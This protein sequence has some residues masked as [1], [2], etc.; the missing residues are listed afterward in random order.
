MDTVLASSTRLALD[1]RGAGAAVVFLH[2]LTFSR[3]TWD[4]IL[5]RLAGRFR[6]VA[7]DLPGHGESPRLPSSIEEV[8]YRIHALII[9]LGIDRPIVVGHSFGG[10]LAS[11]Y[12]ATFPVAG[13]VNVDQPLDIRPFA[14]LLQQFEPALRGPHFIAAFEP[15]RQQIGVELLPEPLRSATLATQTIHQD[16]VLAYWDEALRRSPEDLQAEIDEA[17]RR[18]AV[19]YL[20]VFGHQLADEERAALRDR[21]TGLELEEWPDCGHMVHLMEPDRF[22]ERLAAFVDVCGG[23]YRSYPVRATPPSAIA[24]CTQVSRASRGEP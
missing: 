12:A 5:V 15:I 18:I 13:V 19:P 21:L 4:P 24:D 8:G 20:A 9:D 10:A 17:A 23:A 3:R 16:L 14:R 2:G 1:D 11:M 6:C 7:I 22:A